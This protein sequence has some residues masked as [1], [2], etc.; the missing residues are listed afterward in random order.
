MNES[1]PRDE[2]TIVT[3]GPAATVASSLAAGAILAGRFRVIRFIARG[4][5]GEVYEAEDQVLHDNVALKTIRP[6]VAGDARAMDR[7]LREVHLARTVTHP[8]VCRIYDVFHHGD[9][10]FL[11][12]ELL[13]GETLSERLKRIDRMRPADA[14]PLVEQMAAALGAAHDAGVIHRDFKSGNVMLV[15]DARRAGGSRV[16]VTDFGLA[17]RTQAPRGTS[18]TETKTV[19]GTPDYMAPEQIEGK[20]L[21][22]AADIYA[23]GIVMYEMVTGGPPFQG[24]TP[25]S[26]A[27]KKLHEAPPSPRGSTPDLPAEWDRAIL[28][29]LERDPANRY[30]SA[31]DVARAL[32]GEATAE[33]PRA[34][35]NRRRLLWLALGAAAAVAVAVVVLPRLRGRHA[36]PPQAAASAPA[37]IRTPRRAIAV[38]GFRN[39][40]GRPA[41]AWMSTGLSEMLTTELAA[42]GKLRAIPSESVARMRVDLSLPE[43]DTLAKDTLARVRQN[44]GA[45]LVLLGSYLVLGTEPGSPV[46]VDLRLQDTTEGET[47]AV[48]SEKGAGNELDALIGRAGARLREKLELPAVSAREAQAVRAS[49]PENTDAARLYAEGL[50]KLRVFDANG[51]RELLEKAVAADPR[52]SL[53]HSALAAA[54]SSLGYDA[55]ALAEARLALQTSDKLSRETRLLVEGRY[56]A[57][58]DEWDRA[59]EIYRSLFTFFPDDVEY[60]LLLANAQTRSGHPNDALATLAGIRKASPR[61][62]AR[63]DLTEAETARALSDFPR[64]EKAAMR[65]AAIASGQGARLGVANA[66]LLE[67]SA[68][69]N[70]GDAKKAMQSAEEARRLFDAAGDQGGVAAALN[71]IGNSQSDLG[72]LAAAR[73]SYEG[74]LAVARRIGARRAEAGALDNIASIVGDEGDLGTARVLSDQALAIFREIGDRAGEATTLN[75]IGAALISRGDL[76]G[77]RASFERAV[78]IYREIGDNGGLAIALNNIAE[79]EANQGDV[80]AAAKSYGEAIAIFRDSG[81]RSKSVYP[82]AGLAGTRLEAGDLAEARKMLDEAAEICRTSED[83]HELAFVLSGLGN[84]ALEEDRLADAR[85]RYE[86]ALKIRNE[87]GENAA[88]GQSELDLARLSLEEGDAAAA[89]AKSRAAADA[90]RKQ[91]L[92]DDEAAAVSLSARAAARLGRK[93]DAA[94]A[95]ERAR[96]AGERS[97]HDGV[98]RE[99]V[100]AGA[101]VQA[102]RGQPDA[103]RQALLSAARRASAGGLE[104]FALQARLA[105]LQIALASGHGAAASP[106]RGEADALVT[107][108]RAKGF[109]R[110]AR[111]AAAAP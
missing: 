40:A 18:L 54:W 34:I 1:D 33:S 102:S 43:A 80:A 42:G 71:H 68:R 37:A 23:L 26:V 30:P 55:K 65:A 35:R 84:V 31:P 19:L 8:N 9:V 99:I 95:L 36:A 38:L 75:N 78:P 109:A 77:A 17:R 88:A 51:A 48:V 111:L 93:D 29:C 56:R 83:R 72:D 46:R 89:Y 81:Q 47:L 79:M 82:L 11:T 52:H 105:A 85:A 103:A 107:D 60:G 25:L 108:A 92:S 91:K 45:D 76:E 61:D 96:A 3:P 5:M 104:T 106:V 32:R 97:Q 12:M 22:P 7:F 69:R 21:T 100:L 27:L 44:V 28:R 94:A 6:D 66:L 57:M 70:L 73:K 67:A 2:T 110:I 64:A 15:P 53:A 20:P 39:T 59:I 50:A 49:L 87:L 14:L 74:V 62:D 4:G 58:H 24:D 63:V 98:R 16:V 86:E 10:A 13:A 90:F 41:D 101:A